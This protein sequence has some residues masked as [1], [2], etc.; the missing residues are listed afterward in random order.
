MAFIRTVKRENPFVQMDKYFLEDENL[1][2]ESKGLLAYILSRPDDWKINQTDLANRSS[3][4]KGKVET[5]LLDLLA[6]GYV[7]W[8]P[9]R[10]EIG[11]IEEWVYDVYERPEFNPHKDECIAEGNRRIAEK[12]AKNKRKNAKKKNPESDNPKVDLPESDY[13]EV[14]YPEVDNPSYTNNDF[15]D[16]D[17]KDISSSSS[18][19]TD[20]RNS[21]DNELKTQYPN[22]PFDDVKTELLNDTTAIIDTDKQYRSML[23]YRL[24][25]WKPKQP[26]QPKP[27]KGHATG[28]KTPNRTEKLPEWF[29][30]NE[31]L[32]VEVQEQPQQIKKSDIDDMLKK[33]RQL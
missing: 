6:N 15:K 31:P 12:K 13:P 30:E 27:R 33:L 24:K 2:W 4:G 29:N 21:I 9:V 25:T 18:Y 32:A 3:G 5:A 22:V 17:L 10:N 23:D 20:N 26:K 1:Q 28:R 7:H 16:I 11:R 19:N 14:D 8:Y